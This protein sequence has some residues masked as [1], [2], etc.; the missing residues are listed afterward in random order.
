M[1]FRHPIRRGLIL[2]SALVAV[3]AIASP[4]GAHVSVSPADQA[5]GEYTVLTFGVGHG[6]EEAGTTKV[7]IQIPEPIVNV[8]PTVNL[9]WDVAVT[10]EPLATPIES[11]DGDITVRDAVVTYTKKGEALPHDLRDSFELS[12][13]IPEGTEGDTLNFPTVQTCTEGENAW[14]EIPEAGEDAHSLESPAPF[15]TVAAATTHGD[16]PA[17]DEETAAATSTD[18]DSSSSDTLAIIALIVG[19]LGLGVGGFALA[20]ARKPAV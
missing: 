14:V 4:A 12:L 11:E 7:E 15:V 3:L 8:T 10:E 16:E 19:A 20:K 18:D 9:D 5:A 13:Q 1:K 6:C 2:A 17:D